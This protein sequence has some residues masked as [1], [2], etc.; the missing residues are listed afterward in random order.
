MICAKWTLITK[1]NNI[2]IKMN[3]LKYVTTNY[4]YYYQLITCIYCYHIIT[5][6]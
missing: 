3:T 5:F 4:E 1:Q 2:L 6:S